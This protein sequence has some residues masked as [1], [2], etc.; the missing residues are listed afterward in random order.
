MLSSALSTSRA[1]QGIHP[2]R[3]K[4]SERSRRRPNG[5]EWLTSAARVDCVSVVAHQGQDGLPPPPAWPSR[6]P[7]RCLG[8][9]RMLAAKRSHLSS[10]HINSKSHPRQG[11][12]RLIRDAPKT[13]AVPHRWI[14]SKLAKKLTRIKGESIVLA[15]LYSFSNR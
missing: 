7:S 5:S 2:C 15:V 11:L 4:W 13:G 8:E 12:N 9:L 10:F 1:T 14:G 3:P 6:P